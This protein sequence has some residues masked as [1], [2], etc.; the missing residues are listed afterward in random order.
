MGSTSTW[1]NAVH[2][3]MG[4]TLMSGNGVYLHYMNPCIMK[5]EGLTTTFF[6]VYYQEFL[7]PM[8]HPW[9]YFDKISF[10]ELKKQTNWPEEKCSKPLTQLQ[11]I[12]LSI[13][14]VVAFHVCWQGLWPDITLGLGANVW[15]SW[16]KT[17]SH[18]GA[19]LSLSAVKYD[20][21]GKRSHNFYL[22]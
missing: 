10:F 4:S 11:F 2:R 5:I 17:V 15:K 14:L 18:G 8:L 12:S 3:V 19:W 22:K 7:L 6:S 1:G 20:I 9:I 21:W 13:S 16:E